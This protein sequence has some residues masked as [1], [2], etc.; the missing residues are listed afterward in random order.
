MAEFTNTAVGA[1]GIVMKDK[2]TVWVEPGETVEVDEGET[3]SIHADIKKGAA[4]KKAA[5]KAAEGGETAQ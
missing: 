3:K 1:R 2:T 4:S 5:A